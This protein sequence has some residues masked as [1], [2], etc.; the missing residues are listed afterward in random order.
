MQ[1]EILPTKLNSRSIRMST[2]E[3]CTWITLKYA[4][5]LSPP[6]VK[7]EFVRKYKS[8]GIAPALY[9]GSQISK[10]TPQA[11]QLIRQEIQKNPSNC[12]KVRFFQ[13]YFSQN[14]AKGTESKAI[15]S[16]ADA[17]N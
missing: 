16:F 11:K 9:P 3:Q 12:K 17:R 1:Q 4:K 7:R 6:I 5:N 15:S 2:R 14:S 10:V 13:C 8:R